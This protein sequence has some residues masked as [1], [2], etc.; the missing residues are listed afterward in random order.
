MG[1]HLSSHHKPS[2]M[3]EYQDLAWGKANHDFAWGQANHDFAWGHADPNNKPAKS[4]CLRTT[5]IV[6]GCAAVLVTLG[7]FCCKCGGA[8]GKFTY[9]DSP[10]R[11]IELG[12][13]QWYKSN[14]LS[15]SPVIQVEQIFRE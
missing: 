1:I 7:C 2:A 6:A 13:K 4:K 15:G 9:R 14:T 8:D 11:T 5:L 12:H 10:D 3:F